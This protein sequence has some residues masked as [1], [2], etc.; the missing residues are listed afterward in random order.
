M[1]TA[2]AGL[3]IVSTGDISERFG[4]DGQQVRRVLDRLGI[5]QKIGRYRVVAE[6]DMDTV[7]LALIAAGFLARPEPAEAPA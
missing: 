7:E 3:S 6:A 1:T 2:T 4:V 5:G